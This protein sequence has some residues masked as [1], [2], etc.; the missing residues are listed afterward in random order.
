MALKQY[1][2]THAQG[3]GIAANSSGYYNISYMVLPTAAAI[4]QVDYRES[5][6]YYQSV[7]GSGAALPILNDLR[8]NFSNISPSLTSSAV[9][10]VTIS[11][12]GVRGMTL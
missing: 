1:N 6:D 12:L 5:P 7:L 3:V 10:A 2:F 11:C 4:D 9:W 8:N